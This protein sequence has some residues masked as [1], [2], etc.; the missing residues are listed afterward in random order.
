VIALTGGPYGP[1]SLAPAWR[2]YRT[3]CRA[4][5]TGSTCFA[6][7]ASMSVEL[8]RHGVDRE[9]PL[10]S[11]LIVSPMPRAN[12]CRDQLAI[13]ASNDDYDS[14]D[15]LLCIAGWTSEI[16]ETDREH[17]RRITCSRRPGPK[18]RCCSPIF[19]GAG[20]FPTVEIAKRARSG[21]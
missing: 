19:R 7:I 14:H 21:R 16:A 20:D 10:E 11:G 9:R 18:L 12:R 4:L 8:Q 15:A 17:L 2:S 6:A 13:F 1:I 5:R 3:C